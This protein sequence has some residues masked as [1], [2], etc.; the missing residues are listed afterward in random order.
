MSPATLKMKLEKN[1]ERENK[2]V[3]IKL[4]LPGKELFAKRNSTSFEAA[5]DEVAEALR[6]QVVKAHD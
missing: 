6:R 5:T 4:H 3:D 2:V 1:D